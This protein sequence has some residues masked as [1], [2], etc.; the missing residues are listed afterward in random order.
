MFY[1]TIHIVYI[2]TITNSPY[3]E[4][5]YFNGIGRVEKSTTFRLKYARRGLQHFAKKISRS[6]MAIGLKK[7][8]RTFCF[9]TVEKEVTFIP[10]YN[11][12]ET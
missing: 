1:N 8:R 7:R 10:F 4:V 5:Y 12:K 9:F 2:L 6:G 3:L 11:I